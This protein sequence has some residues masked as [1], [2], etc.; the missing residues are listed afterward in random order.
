MAI[1]GAGEM[2]P[3]MNTQARNPNPAF[4]QGEGVINQNMPMQPAPAPMQEP[5]SIREYLQALQP[6]QVPTFTNIPGGG[7]FAD[8]ETPV[9]EFG[10]IRPGAGGGEMT[11]AGAIPEAPAADEA[12]KPVIGQNPYDMATQRLQHLLPEMEEAFKQKVGNTLSLQEFDDQFNQYVTHTGNELIKHYEQKVKQA[13]KNYN[14]WIK[15]FTG[16]SIQ[17]HMRG[18]GDLVKRVDRQK[19]A[20]SAMKQWNEWEE[21]VQSADPIMPGS[22]DKAAYAQSQIDKYG[23]AEAYIRENVGAIVNALEG[24]L[25][26]Q[27]EE[28]RAAREKRTIP[29]EKQGDV[30]F[31][32]KLYQSAVQG[33]A[34]AG[35]EGTPMSPQDVLARMQ[36]EAP[37][38]YEMVTRGQ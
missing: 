30:D 31:W 28:D 36:Q 17:Q 18:E 19:I 35:L 21:A 12:D 23:T 5:K 22:E 26:K 20:S 33:K 7:A 11:P 25:Q 2:V 38:I 8:Q 34:K 13:E 1:P 16:Q 10:E 14:A 15:D 4:Q 24:E 6:G 37:D 3:G 32:K 9:A 27:T 29:E